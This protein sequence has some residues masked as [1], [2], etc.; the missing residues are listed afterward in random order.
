MVT[1]SLQNERFV[2]RNALIGL[3][4]CG[5]ILF[6]GHLSFVEEDFEFPIKRFRMTS[7]Y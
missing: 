6:H 4:L 7:Y 3:A 2:K 5:P 1:S